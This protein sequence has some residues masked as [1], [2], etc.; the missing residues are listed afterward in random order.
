MVTLPEDLYEFKSLE[1]LNLSSNLFTSNSTI[2]N[3]SL[4]FKSLGGMPKL[5]RLNLSRNK[6]NMFHY[7]FLDKNEDFRFL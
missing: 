7:E 3:P 6:F 2:V 5:K 4:M 1:E